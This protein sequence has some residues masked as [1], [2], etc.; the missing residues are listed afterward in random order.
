MMM[1]DTVIQL[2]QEH[3]SINVK[4]LRK[5]VLKALNVKGSDAKASKK[6]EYK[7]VVLD[8][9]QRKVLQL[10][11]DGAVQLVK[12]KRREADSTEEKKKKRKKKEKKEKKSSSSIKEEQDLSLIHI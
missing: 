8:L 10:G 11:S 12:R 2:L 9:D 4:E 7:T 3:G 5:H 6:K 1:E